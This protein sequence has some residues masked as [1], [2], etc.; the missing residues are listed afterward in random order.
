MANCHYH[1]ERAVVGACVNCG[2]LL[3][4][5]CKTMLGGKIYCNPCANEMFSSSAIP[6]AQ[7]KEKVTYS[8]ILR[9]ISGILGPFCIAL[10]IYGL[11]YFAESGL[12]SE[13]I[14]DVITIIVG[15][16]YLVMA[17]VPHWVSAK[18]NI[19]LGKSSVF[20]IILLSLVIVVFVSI[21]LGPEPPGG[22]ESWE[23]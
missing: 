22:W 3:C 18:L 11:G 12:V 15:V 17:S 8:R 13:L 7:T 23:P 10:G 9:W 5:E 6:S 21:G 4:E 2:K 1:P 16:A 14:V 19:K 20:L